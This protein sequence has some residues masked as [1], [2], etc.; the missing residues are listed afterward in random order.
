MID[1]S[2][3]SEPEATIIAALFALSPSLLGYFIG[4]FTTRLNYKQKQDE[5]FFKALDF[6]RRG[7]QNRNLGISAIQLYW[8]GRRHR[9]LCVSLLVGSAIYLL[10][11]SEQGSA[12]HEVNNLNRIMDM[13]LTNKHTSTA[14]KSQYEALRD[15]LTTKQKQN[16]SH[17]TGLDVPPE[18]ITKWLKDCQTVISKLSLI[19]TAANPSLLLARFRKKLSSILGHANR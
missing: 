7:S 3:Y 1:I 5:L 8:E 18:L 17:P 13:L 19:R 2:K 10:L 6:L 12:P 4:M 11:A 9:T 15:A 14:Q 16:Q